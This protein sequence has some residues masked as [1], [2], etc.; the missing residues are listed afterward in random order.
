MLLTSMIHPLISFFHYQRLEAGEY[1]SLD[2]LN[3][4]CLYPDKWQFS[5]TLFQ[6]KSRAKQVLCDN[7]QYHFCPHVAPQSTQQKSSSEQ[8]YW[9]LLTSL[10][11][12][13]WQTLHPNREVQQTHGRGRQG[14]TR[15]NRSRNTKHTVWVCLGLLYFLNYR[16]FIN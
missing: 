15:K 5:F 4:L 13:M 1:F 12:K 2:H 9:S 8:L 16:R 14:S 3:I 6:N 11:S 7:K 10:W